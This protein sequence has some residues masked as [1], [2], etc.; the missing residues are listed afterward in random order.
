[1]DLLSRSDHAFEFVNAVNQAKNE[2]LFTVSQIAAALGVSRQAVDR[3][4]RS[5]APSGH[6][7]ISSVL[8]KVW[9]VPALPGAMQQRLKGIA[10]QRGFGMAERLLG[11]KGD[12][13]EAPIPMR[14]IETR[15]IEKATRLQRA[16]GPSIERRND[17][18]FTAGEFAQRGLEDYRAEFGITVSADYWRYLLN[19]TL[20]RDR[21]FEQFARVEL[22]L[23]DAAFRRS[24]AKPITPTARYLHRELDAAAAEVKDRSRPGI[25]EKDEFLYAVFA[26]FETLLLESPGEHRT[27]KASLLEYMRAAV[28][29]LSSGNEGAWRRLFDDRYSRWKSGEHGDKRRNNSGRKQ[30]DFEADKIAIGGLAA[31]MEG[32]VSGAQREALRRGMLSEE[33]T[34]HF[35]LNFRESKSYVP[36][37]IRAG[38]T[39]IALKSI[40]FVKG[41]RFARLNGPHIYRDHSDT[42]PGQIT[43]ADDVT[44]PIR[45][46]HFDPA[47]GKWSLRHAECLMFMDRRSTFVLQHR[48]IFG[49]Y[50]SLHIKSDIL[51]EHDLY[52]LPEQYYF[53]NSVWRAR[54][55]RTENPSPTEFSSWRMTDEGLRQAGLAITPYRMRHAKPGN[56]RAK[57][58]ERVFNVLQNRLALEPGF[59]GRNAHL[60]NHER[61]KKLILRAE[62]GEQEALSTFY[63][64]EE[65]GRALEQIIQEYNSDPQN[66]KLL[67]GATPWEVW[68]E[69]YS[70]FPRKKL[71]AELRFIL[72]T[73][74][75]EV[76]PRD[77]GL[78]VT[79]NGMKLT[80]CGEDIARLPRTRKVLAWWH[81]EYPKMITVTDL[82]GQN[83]FVAFLPEAPGSS[84]TP[85]QFKRAQSYIN[86]HLEASR[87][88][89]EMSKPKLVSTITRTG[90]QS[91]ELRNLGEEMTAQIAEAKAQESADKRARNRIDKQARSRGIDPATIRNTRSFEDGL[92]LE[93]EARREI[94]EMKSKGALK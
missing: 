92:A 39:D 52:G 84:A 59:V 77:D 38:A 19:R 91:E 28:P 22:F 10:E 41:E 65:T 72:S 32:N 9:A 2:H 23:D 6:R 66:G 88:V 83:P 48:L 17:M 15:H 30:K 57:I 34:E 79:I 35:N 1:M 89:Y 44:W 76:T 12:R 3:A 53:E 55:L 78:T 51:R 93:E 40:P 20:E 80:F 67:N 75:S 81:I 58:I 21:G 42:R 36:K 68:S 56:A 16:L 26:H 50:N 8:A 54:L 33:Y 27:I 7:V 94:E 37:S 11:A 25:E 90:A 43:E 29:G 18:S 31:H 63:T 45:I 49:K 4:L 71:P 87:T 73:N 14:E 85:E 70:K 82:K 60:D 64:L 5:V 62:S 69:G 61:T 74:R 46:K 86:S 24:K 13:W 47:T